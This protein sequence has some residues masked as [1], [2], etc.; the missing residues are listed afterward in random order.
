MAPKKAKSKMSI[1]AA[2]A[3]SSADAGSPVS[4]PSRFVDLEGQV[5]RL[6]EDFHSL[7]ELIRSALPGLTNPPIP[8]ESTSPSTERS[9]SRPLMPREL[10]STTDGG[11]PGRPEASVAEREEY[12][13]CLKRCQITAFKGDGTSQDVMEL[14]TWFQ[15]AKIRAVQSGARWEWMQVLL[16]GQAL[17]GPAGV[18]WSNLPHPPET[19]EDLYDLLRARFL[20]VDFAHAVVDAFWS[21]RMESGQLPAAFAERVKLLARE[22]FGPA[23]NAACEVRCYIQGL[24]SSLRT[25]VIEEVRRFP[26]APT[27][28]NYM[29]IAQR[30]YQ[31]KQ[32]PNRTREAHVAAVGEDTAANLAVIRSDQRHLRRRHPLHKRMGISE[33][34]LAR[35]WDNG[36]C[37]KCGQPGHQARQ[38]GHN[39]TT[40][41]EE[42]SLMSP[43]E[44]AQQ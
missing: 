12:F 14:A 31:A 20:P 13:R 29:T 30:L 25:N 19:L 42:N 41:Q 39:D 40:K 21:S 34:E 16:V 36:L 22:A 35:R 18:W 17:E 28:E 11:L 44:T 27:L 38:C 7:Q 32:I 1:P 33:E 3:G 9:S 4:T 10:L 43:N 37:W 15:T 6:S 23:G 8:A 5:K 2:D 24:P 26:C